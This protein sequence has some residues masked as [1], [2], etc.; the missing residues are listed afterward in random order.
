M[1]LERGF[2]ATTSRYRV[3]ALVA[4]ARVRGAVADVAGFRVGV[5][6]LAR[7]ALGVHSH[8]VV[9]FG[10]GSGGAFARGRG[11]KVGE[12]LDP[13]REGPSSGG[14]VGALVCRLAR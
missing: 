9:E 7:S 6:L 4:R 1:A 12:L 11:F 3:D 5:V 8:R 2:A 14:A 13:C 10:P